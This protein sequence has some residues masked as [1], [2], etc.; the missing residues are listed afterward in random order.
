LFETT[1][2]RKDGTAFDVEV[3]SNRF[4]V[5]GRQFI[6]AFVRDIT[7]RKLLERALARKTRALRALSACNQVA[8]GATQVQALLDE[9][10]AVLSTLGGYGL[11]WVGHPENDVEKRV[12][13]W[14]KSG[15]HE[16]YLERLQISWED[17]PLGRGPTGTALRERRT[18]IAHNLKTQVSYGPWREAASAQGFASSIALPLLASEACLGVLTA[19]SVGLDA[20]DADEVKLLEE[21]AGNLAFAMAGLQS[22]QQARLL[23]SELAASDE[24]FRLIIEQSPAGIYVVRHGLFVYANPR[25]EEIMGFAQGG[26]VGQSLK[27]LVLA[28]DF[29]ILSSGTERMNLLGSTGNLSVRCR[30]QDG[31]LIELGLQNVRADYEREPAIIGMAQDISERN[32]AQ[33]EIAQYILKL[34][35][36]TEATLQAVSAMVE[37]RDP[38]TAGHERRVGELAGAIGTEMGLTAHQVKG[39]RLSGFVHDV[40]KIAVPAELLAKPTRLSEA[41]MALIRVHSQAGYDVLKGIEFPW[42]IADV[43]LQHHERLD[44]TGYPQGLKGSQ[45]LLEARIMTVAD[46]V[47][48][49][50]SHRPYRPA[51]GIEAA[52]AEITQFSGVRYDA[53]VVEACRRL[54]LEKAY[55]I[56]A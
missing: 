55:R 18:V 12:T 8:L 56:P 34:E 51:L 9:V 42:P 15:L 47:E 1:H 50:A 13:V 31:V 33:A 7:E 27:H 19:Y 25:M 14:A 26:L 44:G 37:Q 16:G 53:A 36:T 2:R 4:E 52:L 10:C 11:A 23:E 6:Q 43:I 29:H 3:S 38:Y 46:V 30:R 21:L 48:S 28:E 54:F 24:R 22:R 32:R 39:L 49:M 41:E 35:R 17:T 5:N 20:F 40:G 45:V